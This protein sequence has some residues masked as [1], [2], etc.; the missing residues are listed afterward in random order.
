M[1]TE[2]SKRWQQTDNQH[3]PR[4]KQALPKSHPRQGVQRESLLCLKQQEDRLAEGT[5]KA[6]VFTTSLSV[7]NTP[8]STS[9]SKKKGS[10]RSS[11]T[12]GPLRR[13]EDQD[14]DSEREHN[15][16]DDPEHVDYNNKKLV[17]GTL[18]NSTDKMFFNTATQHKSL[19]AK[20]W[21]S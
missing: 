19:G 12:G 20:N 5:S 14:D 16:S 10:R 9:S 3:Y 2:H 6:R 8:K 17:Q 21:K 1:L 4:T 7:G 11:L 15:S 13:T 18:H